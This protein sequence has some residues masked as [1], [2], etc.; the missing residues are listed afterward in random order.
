[1]KTSEDGAFSKL[2]FWKSFKYLFSDV[3]QFKQGLFMRFRAII[4]KKKFPAGMRL[5]I[6][7]IAAV[8]VFLALF[9]LFFRELSVRYDAS[10][11]LALALCETK[12]KGDMLHFETLLKTEHGDIYL[13]DGVLTD[14]NGNPIANDNTNIG[15]LSFDLGIKAAIFVKE[16]GVFRCVASGLD[17]PKKT[18]IYDIVI[19]SK[20]APYRYLQSGRE[21]SGRILFLKNEYMAVYRPIFQPGTRNV[22]IG[23]IFAGIEMSDII[24]IIRQESSAHDIHRTTLRI[25]LIVLGFLLAGT[26]ITILL[27]MNADRN[28][29]DER[30]KVTYDAMP[31]GVNVV[32]KKFEFIDCN[33]HVLYLF[34]LSNKQEYFD[35][36][37]MLSPEYQS[38]GKPSKE[39]VYEYLD[40]AFTDGF[41][42][43]E[44]THQKLNGEP[45]PC[46]VTLVRI[47]YGNETA[48]TAY[49][50]DLREIKRLMTEVKRRENLLRTANSAAEILLS[51]NDERSFEAS[52]SKSL[53][54]VGNCID[55]D[56]VQIWRSEM[57]DDEPYFV[58]KYLWLSEF[59]KKCAPVE[60]LSLPYSLMPQWIKLFPHNKYISK[61]FSMLS[62]EREIAFFRKYDLKSIIIVPVFLENSF[63]GLIVI[64]NCHTEHV[65]SDE[66]NNIITSLGL[67][68]TNSVNRNMQSA[69][70]RETNERVQVMFDAMPMGAS[71]HNL[72]GQIMDCNEGIVNLFKLSDKKEFLENYKNYMPEYQSDGKLSIEKMAQETDK[73]FVEGSNHFEW[74]AVD[75]NGA[76]IP[77]DVTLVRVKHYNDYVV[78]AYVRDIRDIKN[79]TAEKEQAIAANKEKSSFLA[80][81]S[82]DVRTPMNAILGITEMQLQNGALLP[83]IQEALDKIYNSGSLLMG[84]INDI[85]DLS[86]IEAGRMEL[87]PAKYDVLN[88]INDTVLVNAMRYNNKLVEFDLNVD[89]KIPST[90][91]G[92][93][94]RIK[95]ILNNLLSN[96]FKYTDAGRVTF[97]V[98]I[99]TGKAKNEG[100][101]V[102]QIA[103]TGH[104]MT[105]EQVNQLFNEYTRFD[106]D[107]NR[108]VEGTGLGLSITKHLVNMMNGSISVKSEPGK[109]SEFTVRLPQGLTGSDPLGSEVTKN[110]RQFHQGSLPSTKK[111][112]KIVR[113]YMPY[114]KVLIVDDMEINLYVAR[115][116]LAPY[117]LSIETALSGYE[118]INKIKNGAKYDII[119]MDHYMP[120]MDGVETVKNIRALNYTKPVIA[121][122][123]NALAGQAEMLLANGFDGYISKP[124]DIRQLN[125]ILNKFVRDKYPAETIEAARRQASVMARPDSKLESY[126]ELSAV[127]LRDAEKAVS[128]LEEIHSNNYRRNADMH[129]FVITVHAMKSALANIGETA[130]S[131]VALNLEQAGRENNTAV[132][133]DGT[134]IFLES[135]KSLIDKIKQ[136]N[137]DNEPVVE[138]SDADRAFFN[139][140]LRVV[141]KACEK[142]DDKAVSDALAELRKKKWPYDARELLETISG[143]LLHSEF[144]KAGKLAED[145]VGSL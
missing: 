111:I 17:T 93:D 107:A 18:N 72:N 96:A 90:L 126:E 99:E 131:A 92:D 57:I 80:K 37:F 11:E 19:N 23:C 33:D 1:M 75:A 25:S 84:I 73:A 7:G 24:N 89:E 29:A 5:N 138:I 51:V 119:F 129:L 60:N 43:Y 100:V 101:L 47:K 79:A 82:H 123:A 10:L 144:S 4:G 55:A 58:H 76:T 140:K 133:K 38:D 42:R 132:I 115:G 39:K 109:G 15:H 27:R 139:E 86:K 118:T 142:Y 77:C 122:T 116:L 88:L 2:Q 62:D 135:L 81:V 141:Q 61:Q 16:D 30:M 94:I 65:L 108:G 49:I 74:V 85:L 41:C 103:D 117:G 91:V 53:E 20:D 8:I 6:I 143:H 121:F 44:W 71:Y 104:G 63:W 54:L 130:L 137:R 40:K 120:K 35:K 98:T 32:N 3:S 46:E 87:K 21:F 134:P 102:L 112:P 13:R 14:E 9:S 128:T 145:Y 22:V 34:G 64:S 12:L 125:A 50:R 105:A 52:L 26:L 124:I 68:I 106:T 45:V 31:M 97:T 36:F 59:G 66:E 110:L 83:E 70:I 78:A 114:G 95:Q 113:E 48:V 28:S 69:K 127:F 56:R 136:E 67:M